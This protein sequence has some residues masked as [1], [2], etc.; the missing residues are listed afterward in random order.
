MLVVSFPW[1]AWRF[2]IQGKNRRGWRQKLFGFA[3][4]SSKQSEVKRIWLHAVSVGEVH[5]LKT[6]VG[7][8]LNENSNLELFISTTTETGFDRAQALFGDKHEVF[9][10]HSTSVGPFGM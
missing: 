1:L 10:F 9:F 6:L 3:P 5:L 8:L 4:E 2:A 7:R